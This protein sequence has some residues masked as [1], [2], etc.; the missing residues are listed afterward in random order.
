MQMGN[1]VAVTPNAI[2]R[3]SRLGYF[4]LVSKIRSI[5]L[6]AQVSFQSLSIITRIVYNKGLN[7]NPIPNFD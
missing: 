5:I 4:M 6:N 7:Q 2:L 3:K 1:E